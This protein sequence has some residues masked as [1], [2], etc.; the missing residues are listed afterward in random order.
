MNMILKFDFMSVSDNFQSNSKI[1][2]ERN[3]TTDRLIYVAMRNILR[4]R[5]E[6]LNIPST[7]SRIFPLIVNHVCNCNCHLFVGMF[8]D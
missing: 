5:R 2:K 6:N 3:F 8:D 7:L 1:D 4:R